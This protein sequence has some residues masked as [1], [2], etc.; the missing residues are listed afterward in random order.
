[1][2]KQTKRALWAILNVLFWGTVMT[3][4]FGES[5]GSSPNPGEI[6]GYLIGSL[7][8]PV[9]IWFGGHVALGR[10]KPKET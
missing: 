3:R 1:M 5:L 6:V 4:S 8:V 10:S 2:T 7:I 9:G